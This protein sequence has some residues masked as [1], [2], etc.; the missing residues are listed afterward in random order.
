VRCGETEVEMGRPRGEEY[1]TPFREKIKKLEDSGLIMVFTDGSANPFDKSDPITFGCV[2]KQ[3]GKIIGETSDICK[4]PVN[5]ISKA[6]IMAMTHALIYLISEG[7][8]FKR[9]AIISDSQFAVNYCVNNSNFLKAN[10][11]AP[12]WPALVDLRNYMNFFPNLKAYWIPRDLNS[13][14]DKMASK[15][16]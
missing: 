6:E 7:M 2:V 13:E 16:V 14:A 5:T 9:V 10:R 12:Y 15:Y 1:L 8:A 4:D 3:G 11:L